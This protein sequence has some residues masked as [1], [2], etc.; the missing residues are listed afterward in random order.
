MKIRVISCLLAGV[1]SL[2]LLLGACSQKPGETKK[3]PAVT[4][5]DKEVVTMEKAADY[6][7]YTAADYN[8]EVPGKKE[9]L[10]MA[11]RAFRELPKPVGNNAR[12]APFDVD[13]SG[14]PQWAL[15]D[16]KKLKEAGIL[17]QNDLG[18][19]AKPM[20]NRTDGK[21]E[22]AQTGDSGTDSD[23]V[24]QLDSVKDS[25]S[26][27]SGEKEAVS[28]GKRLPSRF[29]KIEGSGLGLSIV[30][31]IMEQYGGSVTVEDS[32]ET[33]STIVLRFICWDET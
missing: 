24:S 4:L 15:D 25:V 1:L 16:I 10:T 33:G 26:E 14:V 7:S 12:L 3:G 27:P 28:Q 8:K 13:L 11:S 18:I 2:S 20:E 31:Q 32:N 22:D 6:L 23:A 17:V 30:R 9:L 21:M 19:T 5:S 29:Q